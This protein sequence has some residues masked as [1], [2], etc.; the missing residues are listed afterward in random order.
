MVAI[1]FP[2]T[3][4]PA[5]FDNRSR[6]PDDP[7]DAACRL[8]TAASIKSRTSRGMPRSDPVR[9]S[10]SALIILHAVVLPAPCSRPHPSAAAI[11]TNYAAS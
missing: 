7:A 6:L 4:T 11:S 2:A 5:C 1:E 9:G 3:E 8:A 10:I